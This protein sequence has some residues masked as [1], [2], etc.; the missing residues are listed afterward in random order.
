MTSKDD[1]K[2]KFRFQEGEKVLC[3]HGPLIYE[4]KCLKTRRNDAGICEYYIH[5]AGW[6][7][8]WDE[9]MT[10]LRI[11]KYNEQNL[12]RQ[13]ELTKAHKDAKKMR[14]KAML[15]AAAGSVASTLGTSS[16]NATSK[17]SDIVT[18][19][20][21][22]SA[23]SAVSDKL[24]T[25][26]TSS[27]S[28]SPSKKKKSDPEV[29]MEEEFLDKVEIKVKVPDELKPW[30]VDD[31]DLICRQRKLLTLPSKV[32]VDEIIENYIKQKTS[33]K[34][35]NSANKESA[36]VQTANSIREYFNA[37]LGSQLLY[38]YER[39]QYA[40]ILEKFPDKPMSS[41]YGAAHLLRLFVILGSLIV[42]TCIN[43]KTVQVLQT[44]LQDF[45]RYVQRNTA[46]F[47]NV[48]NYSH[49]SAEYQ[50]RLL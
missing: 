27:D 22:E 7:K 33:G 50:R 43:E 40:E 29:E 13:R 11:L 2:K 36:A 24:V 37:T 45:L 32:T 3:F 21:D 41:I 14:G 47:F 46:S 42:Y 35:A 31:W 19:D 8:S 23:P 39:V 26:E 6:K 1:N 17:S 16:T 15:A 34:N 18:D 20:E 30:L 9:W 5:Y 28:L 49:A 48:Q 25:P 44:Q 12:T 38:K 10:D 4:A